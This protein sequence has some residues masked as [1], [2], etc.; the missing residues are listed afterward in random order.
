MS[1][2]DMK[3]SPTAARPAA[4]QPTSG[5]RLEFGPEPVLASW[6]QRAE[7]SVLRQMVELVA[8]P[9]VVSLAGG[10]PAPELFPREQLAHAYD[11]VLRRE[12]RALQY[13][14]VFAPLKEHIQSLVRRRGVVC[15]VEQIVLTT[16]AQQALDVLARLFVDEGT[17]VVAEAQAYTGIHQVV[18]PRGGR[19][20]TVPTD[21]RQGLD[22]E[23]VAA[24]L[25]AGQARMIY[26]IPE[27]HNPL[28]VTLAPSRRSALAAAAA[29]YGVPIVE[30]DPYGFLT[31]DGEAEPALASL[32]SKWVIYV[33]SFSK[34]L[35]P[36][37]RLG[38]MVLP[39]NLVERA[40]I[41]KEGL[42]LECSS[43]TQRVVAE[44]LDT[45]DF[46]DAHLA[47]LRDTY[48]SRRNAVLAGLNEAGLRHVEWSE[49]SSGMFVWLSFDRE[50]LPR[51]FDTRELLQSS[52]AEEQLAFIPGAAFDCVPEGG[53]RY[54]LRLSFSLLE[55]E[56]SSD[57]I[58][59]LAR[60][61]RSYY[62]ALGAE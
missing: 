41:I 32:D 53:G 15:D 10:L 52:L 61:I 46:F 56:A 16:G 60:A 22:P 59:R 3:I 27:G 62:A 42:D 29:R 21:F 57:A 50:A 35:G 31:Y 12:P 48:R 55:P 51:A 33:G 24:R 17:S 28:G 11:A 5:E 49:P 18:A 54:G 34:I 9:G 45:G 39:K 38:W 30:D 23:A 14:P 19:L 47:R 8:R 20:A 37:L 25:A 4:L 40:R 58:R 2:K 1:Q 43:L 26:A 44:L 36:A 13:L 6:I 7:R